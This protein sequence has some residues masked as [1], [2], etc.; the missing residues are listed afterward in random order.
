MDDSLAFF[1]AVTA[2][3]SHELNNVIAIMDQ[4]AG[5]LEDRLSGTGDEITIPAAKLE[6][7]VT[8]MQNQT[9]RGLGIIKR[10]NRFAHSADHAR[11]KFDVG[12]T[13]NNLVQLTTRLATLRG[14]S[15]ETRFPETTMEIEANPFRLQQCVFLALKLALTMVQKGDVIIVALEMPDNLMEVT[16]EVPGKTSDTGEI[17]ASELRQVMNRMA[18]N[19]DIESTDWHLCI[20]LAF[21][22]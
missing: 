11:C 10:L 20:H 12:E 3:V 2:S 18:G 7:I 9:A 22:L 8:S 21:P 4:T 6:K 19:V 15:L 5:L 1:G 17:D 16:V 14:A 13:M